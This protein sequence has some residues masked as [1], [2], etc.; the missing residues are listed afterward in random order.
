MAAES[1]IDK[2]DGEYVLNEQGLALKE[3]WSGS[4]TP[5]PEPEPLPLPTEEKIVQIY[6]IATTLAL[7][8]KGNI[9]KLSKG[10]WSKIPKPDF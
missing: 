2:V 3:W 5:T 7:T 6:G 1:I 8:S 9:F 4:V 10:K